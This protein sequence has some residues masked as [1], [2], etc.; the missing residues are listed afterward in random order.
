MVDEKNLAGD[1][2][3]RSALRLYVGDDV[4]ERG[5]ALFRDGR[6][7]NLTARGAIT[8]ATV[9]DERPYETRVRRTP[10][11]FEGQCSCPESEGFD[12]CHHCV[13]VALAADVRD[14]A[15][16]AA[17][18]GPPEAR[19]KVFLDDLP[20]EKLIE[21]IATAA[22]DLPD[23]N[24]RL[25]LQADVATGAMDKRRARKMVTAAMPL[26]HIWQRPQVRKY[27]A[28]AVAGINGIV[29]VAP[30]MDPQIL[31]NVADY[32]LDRHDAVLERIDDSDGNRWFLQDRLRALFALA[33]SR[34]DESAQEKATALLDRVLRDGTDLF[35]DDF[36]DIAPILGDEVVQCFYDLARARLDDETFESADA[37]LARFI[38][39][40]ILRADARRRDD[41]ASLI[42]LHKRDLRG[43]VDRYQLAELYLRA[44]ELEQAVTTL[45]EADEQ[46]EERHRNHEL[47][48]RILSASGDVE[49]ALAGQAQL[50]LQEPS[51]VAYRS[52]E[53]LGDQAGRRAIAVRDATKALRRML[54]AGD[55]RRGDAADLLAELA[56][57]RGNADEAFALI[58]E[59]VSDPDR[60]LE[61]V[62]WFEQQEP[63][64]ATQLVDCAVEATIALKKGGAYKQVVTI[65]RAHRDV[66]DHLGPG[67]F[68]SF[69][70]ALKVRHEQK[71]NLIALLSAAGWS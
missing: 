3:T 5:A 55:T 43:A 51:I 42:E 20:R 9:T 16:A 50:L 45:D 39:L 36:T 7:A 70:A 4:F 8:T 31:R 14:A 34:G 49:G 22:G 18:D 40:K 28:K 35:D 61:M 67:A 44:G 33:L 47:R 63:V 12:F 48:V 25:Q 65:L 32:A 54:N 57:E 1:P 11:G 26:R 6:V 2:E 19:L 64:R 13:A 71:R 23:L 46:A 29:E 62:K 56:F 30:I 38:L 69:V 24:D 68:A 58:V 27:F 66:F 17:V 15:R 21:L 41:I 53:R 59:H 10:R 37:A 60:L 52:L